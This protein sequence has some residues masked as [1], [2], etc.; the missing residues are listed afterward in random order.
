M[1]GR[2][3]EVVIK[4]FSRDAVE[5]FLRFLYSGA[6][7]ASPGMLV[8]V[9]AMALKYETKTLHSLCMQ[10]ISGQKLTPEMACE[11]FASA[12]RFRMPDLRTEAL[13]KILVHPGS[14][15]KIRP[16][17]RPE[18]LEEILD[19][20]LLCMGDADQTQLFRGWG[21]REDALQHIIEDRF[22]I[23][24]LPARISGEHSSNVL[25][26]LWARYEKSGQK[27]AFLGYWVVPVLGPG[28]AQIVSSGADAMLKFAWGELSGAFRDGWVKWKL[29]YSHV[30]PLGFSFSEDCKCA[31]LRIWC[32]DDTTWNLAYSADSINI[33]PQTILPCKKTKSLVKCFKLEVTTVDFWRPFRGDFRIHGILQT[34]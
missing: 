6:V 34:K 32:K 20:G 27:G 4:D 1:E 7:E 5:I 2:E 29:P 3:A 23:T 24:P 15:L 30:Y 14:A 31:N 16:Q 13:E 22:S 9:A 28:Q 11:V 19:S 12:D 25:R 8:E 33:T 18:L 17:L 21:K 26:S 10:E